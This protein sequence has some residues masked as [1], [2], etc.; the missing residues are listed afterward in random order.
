MKTSNLLFFILIIF[1]YVY[2]DVK[3]SNHLM[4]EPGQILQEENLRKLEAYCYINITYSDQ[5]KKKK[6]FNYNNKDVRGDITFKIR[7]FDRNNNYTF[8]INGLLQ[9]VCQV[10]K[11]VLLI[12][13]Q[14]KLTQTTPKK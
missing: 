5:K 3:V 14:L 13:F 2:A 7:G 10:L 9:F 11:Q 6:T 1:S 8:T 4:E 12:F